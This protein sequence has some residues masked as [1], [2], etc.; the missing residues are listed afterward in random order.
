MGRQYDSAP[1]GHF[2]INTELESDAALITLLLMNWNTEVKKQLCGDKSWECREAFTEGRGC[3]PVGGWT[4][5]RV[6]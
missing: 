5:P 1:D 3:A 4:C 6:P 2:L